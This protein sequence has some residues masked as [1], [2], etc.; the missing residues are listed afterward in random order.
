M[1]AG[2]R[3]PAL[4]GLALMLAAASPALGQATA[5]SQAFI[6]PKD[7]KWAS[8][9]TSLPKGAMVAVLQGDPGKPGPF[10]MRLMMPA[11]Y[12]VSPHWHSQ[13]EHLTVISGTLYIGMGDRYEPHTARGL[14]AGGFH[15]LP[16]KSHH[17]AYAKK[18]TVVQVNGNGPF[19]ITYIN[20]ADDPRKS[21]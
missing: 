5:G 6:S 17:F 3:A 9:P 14:A 19:D 1:N 12:K 4:A 7:I 2:M 11:G 15:F 8:A 20:P 13:D 16:G 21:P 18:P 10:V